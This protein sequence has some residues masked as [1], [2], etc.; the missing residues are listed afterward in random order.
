MA[1][2]RD[3]ALELGVSSEEVLR[4]LTQM[5]APA[6]SDLSPVEAS[7]ADELRARFATGAGVRHPLGPA[8]FSSNSHYGTKGVASTTERAPS[9]APPPPPPRDDAERGPTAAA[10]RRPGLVMQLAELPLLVLLAF[11]IAVVIKTFVVQAFFIPSTSMLPTLKR[12]DRVLVEKLSFRLREPRAGDVVVF[13]KSVF[14]ARAPELPWYQDAR[15]FLR[16]L[17]GLPTGTETDYIK[18]IVA[19]GGDTIR[20][21]GTPRLL[22]V[23]GEV[24][25]EPYLKG[26]GDRFSPTLTDGDCRRLDMERV[27]SGCLVPEGRV[28]VMGDNRENSEDSRVIGPVSETKVVGHAF[29]VIWPPGHVSGL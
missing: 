26:G 29:V 28:F 5:G 7:V 15:N 19:V 12:G 10:P 3:V 14:G 6:H 1:T 18:R 2:V 17:L 11:A 23:N 21:A 9:S 8:A 16:E 4:G 25:R 22:T 13:A 20:Y 24:V 27:S